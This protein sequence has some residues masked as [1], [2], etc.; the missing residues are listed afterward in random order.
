MKSILYLSTTEWIALAI[1][2]MPL[3]SMAT[4]SHE[5]AASDVE[6]TSEHAITATQTGKTYVQCNVDENLVTKYSPL[7][8]KEL[9]RNRVYY[10]LQV[11]N[12]LVTQ[13]TTTH[14]KCVPVMT[15]TKGEIAGTII[16]RRKKCF[17]DKED[18][19]PS[20]VPGWMLGRQG[21]EASAQF[22]CSY[23]HEYNT[24]V[25]WI[26]TPCNMLS[27]HVMLATSNP[28]EVRYVFFI[29]TKKAKT[30]LVVDTVLPTDCSKLKD[31]VNR[32][33]LSE[34]K[35]AMI[36]Q[37]IEN[38]PTCDKKVLEF[39]SKVSKSRK[40]ISVSECNPKDCKPV[41]LPINNVQ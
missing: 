21:A 41:S 34:L 31:A 20:T 9:Q 30:S 14:G 12:K 19:F 4:P 15:D 32:N 13:G 16:P 33:D 24:T 40:D 29:P 3:T 8:E 7:S 2:A 11:D 25:P 5:G 18:A 38:G 1:F 28:D 10:L 27:T 6:G 37:A 23:D 17:S 35:K 22:A 26:P 36:E 39:L